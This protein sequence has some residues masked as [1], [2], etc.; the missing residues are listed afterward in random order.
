LRT[1]D[2]VF[3]EEKLQVTMLPPNEPSMKEGAASYRT[4]PRAKACTEAEAG[5]W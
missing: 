2:E 4:L 5:V 1:N 3:A